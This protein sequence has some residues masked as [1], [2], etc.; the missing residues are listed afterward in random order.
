MKIFKTYF[1][2]A[3]VCAITFSAF[4]E[5]RFCYGTDEDILLT[6]TNHLEFMQDASP[7]FTS[8]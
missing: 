4:D 8:A 3:G 7:F 6:F 5:A 2:S 1:F